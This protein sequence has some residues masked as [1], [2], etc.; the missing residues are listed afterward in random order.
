MMY[1]LTGD[2]VLY[3]RIR[4]VAQG[5]DADFKQENGYTKRIW[6][7]GPGD[8]LV[9]TLDQLN[10]YQ[11][12]LATAALET[13]RAELEARALRSAR[14]LKDRFFDPV[15]G[16]FKTD[17][18]MPDGAQAG[19]SFGH[20]IK[21][22]WFIDQTAQLAGD[23]ALARF[24]SDGAA[25]V[26][27]RAFDPV[28]GGWYAGR[29][30]SGALSPEGVWWDHAELSQYAA[31]LAISRPELRDMLSDTQRFWLD[32]YVDEARNGIFQRVPLDG[33]APDPDAPKHFQWKAGFHSFEH[34][35]ISYLT[36]SAM[37]GAAA[38]LFFA[39]QNG[40]L[41]DR[42]AYGFFGTVSLVPGAPALFEEGG[43]TSS[44]PPVQSVLVSDIGFTDAAATVVPLPAGA[45]LLCG[46]LGLLAVR[47]R[48]GR[49]ASVH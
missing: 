23:M 29:D 34:A 36:A 7:D 32:R 19:Q 20:T 4:T 39:R 2:P 16:L 25:N 45:W 26:F 24:A 33:S 47:R 28:S 6:E 27:A 35:F 37:E 14:D 18:T 21:A 42:L 1:Y 13:D 22:L 5:I 48:S 49:K 17:A 43:T 31:A 41:P 30:D 3:D 12:L 38:E 40:V 8:Q 46:A 44:A 15:T 11:T 10:S 9:D